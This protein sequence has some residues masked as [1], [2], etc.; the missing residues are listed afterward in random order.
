MI[1]WLAVLLIL[2]TFTGLMTLGI[3]PTQA[4]GLAHVLLQGYL[5]L[6]TITL[7]IGIFRSGSRSDS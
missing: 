6:L 2:A 3:I 1:R 7:V 5:I 4:A